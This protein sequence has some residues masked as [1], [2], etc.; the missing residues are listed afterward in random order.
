[1]PRVALTSAQREEASLNRRAQWLA[2]GLAAYR[3]KERLSIKQFGKR[4][5]LSDK[6]ITK[7]LRAD[8]DVSLPLTTIWRLES[9]AKKVQIDETTDLG[10]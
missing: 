4:V 7:L 2:N 3:N 9:L 8:R 10:G 5:G 1:M 6:T